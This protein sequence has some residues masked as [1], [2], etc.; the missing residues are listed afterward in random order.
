M[1]SDYGYWQGAAKATG[2]MAATGMKLLEFQSNRAYQDAQLKMAQDKAQREEIAFKHAETKRV[3]QER[4]ENA[5]A[6]VST[7]APNLNKTPKTKALWME[8]AKSAGFDLKEMPDGEVY[9]PI[10]AIKFIGQ[11][12]A[13]KTEFQKMTL[14]ATLADL[15]EQNGAIAQ[16]IA[17]LSAKGTPDEKKLAP[18]MEQQ[19]AIKKNIAGIITSEKAVMEKILVARASRE[20][21]NLT[22]EQLTARALGGDTQAQA[23][24]DAMQKRKVDIAKNTT[25]ARVEITQGVQDKAAA[26]VDK[27]AMKIGDAI[28]EGKQPPVVAGFG[29]AKVAPQVRA[30]LADKGFDLTTAEQDYNATKK[31]LGSL[32]STQQ[33]RLRQATT[34]AYDSLD[35]IEKLGKEWDAGRFAPLNWVNLQA[36][37][38]GVYGKEAAKIS[39]KLDAQIAD[40]TSELGTVYK[41]GNSSTD[42]SL[43]L[44]AQNLKSQWD[45]DV[46]VSNIDQIRANLKIRQ[47]SMKFGGA[48][49]MGVTTESGA[50][51]GSKV[52]TIVEQRK[53]SDG[54]ILTKYSDGSI[55]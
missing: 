22:E 7:F 8:T 30:Y 29:M 6:P 1:G 2:D 38:T 21:G 19:N 5:Y 52:R 50:K 20:G 28:M 23:V 42:E 53:T 45:Y 36:A 11:Q 48:T 31:Y 33:V 12:M 25:A 41:G 49:R 3:E 55:E 47:N 16:Q 10:K 32:N 40:L 13:T 17:E 35:I 34:F 54:R 14:D 26:K 43:K 24:L 37:K 4:M 9:A 44:A 51:E 15:Q 27:V 46:L 18:L 39:T